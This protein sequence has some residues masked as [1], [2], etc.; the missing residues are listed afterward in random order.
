MLLSKQD[1]LQR[2]G[3][4]E[5]NIHQEETVQADYFLYECFLVYSG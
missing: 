3:Y 4:E 2:T 5:E 1:S